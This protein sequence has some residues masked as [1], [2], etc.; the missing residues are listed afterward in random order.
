V[1]AFCDRRVNATQKVGEFGRHG[2]K[3]T[4]SGAIRKANR[5]SRMQQ[6][7]PDLR[8]TGLQRTVWH[9]YILNTKTMK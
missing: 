5:K 8:T 1:C 2:R 3:A 6:L 7:D 9:C 4:G